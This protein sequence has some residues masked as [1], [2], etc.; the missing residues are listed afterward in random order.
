[1]VVWCQV[2]HCRLHGPRN[3]SWN[4]TCLAQQSLPSLQTDLYIGWPLQLIVWVAYASKTSLRSQ[5]KVECGAHPK[6]YWT[7]ST[8]FIFLIVTTPLHGIYEFKGIGMLMTNG[9]KIYP[10]LTSPCR[11]FA[12]Q[13]ND[14]YANDGSAGTNRDPPDSRYGTLEPEGTT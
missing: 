8:G 14:E 7:A 4:N 3:G 5:L 12:V 6:T 11:F 9:D 10:N 13:W 1:M 2:T